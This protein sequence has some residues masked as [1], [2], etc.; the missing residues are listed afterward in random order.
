[1][2]CLPWDRGEQARLHPRLGQLGCSWGIKVAISPLLPVLCDLGLVAHPLW[3]SISTSEAQEVGLFRGLKLTACSH[4]LP[5][6]V[7]KCFRL[8]AG[9]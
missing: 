5:A 9:T 4:I 8:A 2:H 3:A 7:F 1:M 6:E